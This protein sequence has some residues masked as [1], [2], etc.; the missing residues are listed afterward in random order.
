MRWDASEAAAFLRAPGPQSHKYSRGVLG[1]RTGSAS[2]PGAAALNAEAAWRTGVGLVRYFAP[3]D[4]PHPM[5]GLPSPAA[6]ILA[7]R[8]ETVFSSGSDKDQASC[9]AWLIGSGTDS[10]ARSPLEESALLGLLAQPVMVA[11]DAGALDLVHI[12]HRNAQLAA[13]VVITPHFGEFRSLWQLAGLGEDPRGED[14]RSESESLAAAAQTLAKLLNVTVLLK[15]S[16]TLAASPAGG[17]FTHGPA[18]P[19]LATAGTGDVLAGILGALLATN[20][21]KLGEDPELLAKLGATAAMLHDTA[22]RIAASDASGDGSGHP[23]TALDVAQSLPRALVQ[24][25]G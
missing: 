10:Q 17:M 24:L 13:H 23:I 11:V 6:A 21:D 7:R 14:I 15:G 5:F 3:L 8:P 16:H 4:E 18:T 22:A 1:L 25:R 9:D 19:W 2:Y 20:A 12:A